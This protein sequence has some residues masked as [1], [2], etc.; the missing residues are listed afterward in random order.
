MQL[1]PDN[2]PL[3]GIQD[4]SLGVPLDRHSYWQPHAEV[5]L[6]GDSEPPE[7][8]GGGWTAWTTV[9]G[10]STY[11]DYSGNSELTFDYLGGGVFSTGG[12]TGN[13]IYAGCKFGSRSFLFVAGR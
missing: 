1:A 13:G 10:A 8:E 5:D 9:S 7:S 11:T 6:I 3:T 4:L 2:R 12:G